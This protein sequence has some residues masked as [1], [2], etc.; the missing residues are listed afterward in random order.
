M[1][2]G[3][4][5]ERLPVNLVTIIRRNLRQRIARNVAMVFSVALVAALTTVFVAGRS[6][7]QTA[8]RMLA[9]PLIVVDAMYPYGMWLRDADTPKIRALPHIVDLARTQTY[10]G[11]SADGSFRFPAFGAD[12][13][14]FTVVNKEGVWFPTDAE[15]VDRWRKDRTAFIVAEQTAE[16]MGFQVGKQYVL[17]TSGGPI[18][19]T[20]AGIS[21]GGANRVNLVMHYEYVDSVLGNREG[22]ITDWIV[23]VTDLAHV[24]STIEA[25]D[26]IFKDT[27]T[28]TASV[29]AGDHI[30]TQTSKKRSIVSLLGLVSLLTL[31][32]T[33]FIT[34]NTVLFLVR[35]RRHVLGALRAI[36]FP[37]THVFVLI[38]AEVMALC[39]L[40]GIIGV[41]LM[42][43]VFRGGIPFGEGNLQVTIPPAA[44]I[45]GLG[46][47]VVISLVASVIPSLL[48]LRVRIIDALR[49]A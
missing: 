3:P 5:I 39:L 27:P 9:N 21:R 8:D 42:M 6:F 2:F 19:V 22:R 28:K 44:I 29:P 36:G 37:N 1:Q 46:V 31:F 15:M 47:T 41:G 34:L 40:G 17:A 30:A 45:A 35:E 18:T 4:P 13:T 20:C 48:A 33:L 16:K 32:V 38:M 12:E 43:L 25:I 14:Y 49:S 26:A 11:K 7:F 23:R 24:E 10:G